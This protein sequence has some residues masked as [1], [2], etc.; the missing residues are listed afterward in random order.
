MFAVAVAASRRTSSPTMS[1]I[2]SSI[3][4]WSTISCQLKLMWNRSLR[5]FAKIATTG[6]DTA[7][8]TRPPTTAKRTQAA[9]RATYI[10]CWI[11]V[12]RSK[13]KTS[14]NDEM[15]AVSKTCPAMLTAGSRR[16]RVPL[17]VSTKNQTAPSVNTAVVIQANIAYPGG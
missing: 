3:P 9:T 2:K 5:S 12:P 7:A 1:A 13:T 17:R 16:R 15:I 8:T 11:G 4:V 14:T 10:S 6:A